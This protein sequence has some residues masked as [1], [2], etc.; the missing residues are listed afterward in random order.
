MKEKCKSMIS[1]GV[2]HLAACMEP[3]MPMIIAGSLTKI[4]CIFIGMVS[5]GS[6]TQQIFSMIG[7]APFYFLPVLVAVTAAE[8]F[9][10]D[11]F[12]AVTAAGILILPSLAELFAGEQAVTFLWIPLVEASYSYSILPVILLVWLVS[13]LDPVIRRKMPEYLMGN[14]Y[15]F[16]MLILLAVL[17]LVVVG[18]LATLVTNGIVDALAFLSEHASIL[19]WPVLAGTSIFFIMTGTGLVFDALALTQINAAGFEGGIMAAFFILNMALVGSDLAVVLRRRNTELGQKAMGAC[20]TALLVG[21]AEPSVFGICLKEKKVLRNVVIACVA[22]GIFQGIVNIYAYVFSFP[23]LC[24]ILMFY[25]SE[26]V[27][28]LIYVLVAMVIAFSVSFVLSYLSLKTPEKNAD[29][30]NECK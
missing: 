3:L 25:S 20:V 1:I 12:L 16:L 6:Y 5:P 18:P 30:Q 24:A 4:L 19:A 29:A 14:V 28:N 27:H 23:G 22:A 9:K 26:R 8:H 15:P 7:D 21:V 2:G 10:L 11:R 17:G 13:K